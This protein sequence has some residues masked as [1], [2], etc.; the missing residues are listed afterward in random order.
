MAIPPRKFGPQYMQGDGTVG[1]R[2]PTY[3]KPIRS[4]EVPK[5]KGIQISDDVARKIADALKMMLRDNGS[6]RR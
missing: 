2:K 1:S 6:K 5:P 4:Q 3:L